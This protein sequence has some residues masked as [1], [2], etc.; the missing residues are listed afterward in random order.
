MGTRRGIHVQIYSL[1]I[2][3]ALAILMVVF[4]HAGELGAIAIDT[5][6]EL[7]VWNTLSGA[8]TMFIFISGFLFH[9]AFVSRFR[10]G[11]FIEKKL[12]HLFVPYLLLSCAA[13]AVGC[14]D[15]PMESFN[16]DFGVLKAGAYM[17]A[18]GRATVA[19]WFVPF[20]L[21]LF[22]LAPLH[23]KFVELRLRTQLTIVGALFV[24]ALLIHRP[25]ANVGPVQN[26]LYYT[27]TYLLGMMCSQHRA[28]A[29][30]LLARATWPL[31][32]ATFGMATLQALLGVSGNYFKPIFEFGGLDLML[33]QKVCLCLFLMAFLRRFETMRS[34]SIDVL[35]NTSFAI[36]FLHPIV[37]E[38]FVQS[39]WMKPYLVE[40]SWMQF[41]VIS[42]LCVA[43][44]AS[45]AWYVRRAFGSQSRYV[46][47]Y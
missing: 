36:F 2:F 20:V 13:L 17:L 14:S 32:A 39:P 22:T 19:Y 11:E 31:L 44:C 5:L 41:A 28:I 12:K 10:F 43:I 6:P 24:I 9:H 30:P 35:A 21:T 45:M 34:K 16:G 29:D 1:A 26:L 27:P 25:V 7:V 18:S 46:T 37:L 33:L 40:E 4:S 3:R 38:V 47:G 15:V 8:T 42:T 23:A